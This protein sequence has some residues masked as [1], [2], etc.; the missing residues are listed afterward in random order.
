MA[1]RKF[2]M[3]QRTNRYDYD[4]YMNILSNEWCWCCAMWLCCACACAICIGCSV[5]QRVQFSFGLQW[6]WWLIGINRPIFNT[7]PEHSS[8]A[9]YAA[10]YICH[11]RERRW[12]I[13]G[14]YFK[15]QKTIPATYHSNTIT[16]LKKKPVAAFMPKHHNACN[17]FFFNQC[18]RFACS[19]LIQ[20]TTHRTEEHGKWNPNILIIFSGCVQLFQWS[21]RFILNYHNIIW[22]LIKLVWRCDDLSAFVWLVVTSRH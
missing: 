9:F 11:E 15:Y 22:L 6:F 17:C 21:Q 1:I 4:A 18:S 19:V 14:K 16:R 8:V 5:C 10:K 2:Q 7:I 13:H 12:L 3:N 20:T